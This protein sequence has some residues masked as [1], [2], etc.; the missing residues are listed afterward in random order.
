MINREQT[1]TDLG[2]IK[3]HKNVIAS[4][5][6]IAAAEIEGVK[7]VGGDLKS[8]LL[9]FIGQKSS[10]AIKVEFVRNQEIRI[11]VPIVIRYGY[12][13]PDVA[14]KAQESVRQALEKMTDLTVK[15][16]NISVQAVERG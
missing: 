10:L 2:V 7:K 13:I 11:E 1:R 15:D 6:S 8:G 16:I 14:G 5:A 4:V 9:E 3:I 12:H